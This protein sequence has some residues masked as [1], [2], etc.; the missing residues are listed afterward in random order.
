MIPLVLVVLAADAFPWS[1][2]QQLKADDGTQLSWTVSRSDGQVTIEGQ[3]SEW[4]VVHVARADGT[5]V[6]TVKKAKG[7]TMRVA[8]R[9]GGADFTPAGG[10]TLKVEEAGLWDAESLDARLAGIAWKPGKTVKFK[11]LDVDSD[12]GSVYPMIAE[13]L[14]DEQC[15]ARKCQAVKLTLDGW[16]RPWG[17]TIIFRYGADASAAY[18]ATVNGGKELKA[19]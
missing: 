12:D 6:S 1:G 17:P 10:K 9:E 7:K 3:H 18:L 4:S 19:R 13:G 15:G 8:Y 11:I 16:R 5:P 2:T 14:G